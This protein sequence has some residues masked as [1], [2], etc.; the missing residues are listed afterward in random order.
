MYADW[1]SLADDVQN[2]TS[3]NNVLN[4]FPSTVGKDVV[5]S[6]MKPLVDNSTS[7]SRAAVNGPLSTSEQVHWTMQVIGHGFTLPLTE[8]NLIASCIDVYDVWLSSL[9]TP[10]SSVPTPV[11]EDPDHY[12]QI[13]F[14]QFS[15]L[16]M[17]RQQDTHQGV[18][19][20]ASGSVHLSTTSH[21]HAVLCKRVLQVTHLVIRMANTKFSRETWQALFKYLLKILDVLLSPPPE[22]NG[23][24]V[25]LCS[26]LIH[27]LFEA[28]LCACIACFP[29]PSLW[30]T[31]RELCC[32]WL[33]HHNVVQQ[34]NKVIYSLTLRVIKHLYTPQYL[35]SVQ[36]SLPKEDKDFKVILD[37][38]PSDV[39]V[40]CWF[41]MLHT[42]GNPA[43][44]SYPSR[45]LN[46]PAFKKAIDEFKANLHK[47][48]HH[49]QPTSPVEECLKGLPE[50]F[51]EAMAGVATLVYL[52]LAQGLPSREALAVETTGVVVAHGSP[53]N[54]RKGRDFPDSRP[55]SLIQ[56]YNH[57]P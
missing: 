15:Q 43:E 28:W 33:H 31:L 29:S 27:V 12:A 18:G 42:I 17:P 4:S 6:I 39:L 51:R 47:H 14:E 2:E 19:V 22:P 35:S 20:S 7:Q 38:M 30:K 21:N 1:E 11:L 53:A 37:G 49:H 9:H 54:S 3:P 41:R 52:F 40:Q 50:I 57:L 25:T 8:H 56:G 13:I 10:K 48:K 5:Q 34:W 23:L 55:G 26:S 16:F 45:M 36:S 24:G 46:S 44:V 32:N